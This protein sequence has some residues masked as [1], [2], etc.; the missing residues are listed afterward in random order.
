MTGCFPMVLPSGIFSLHTVIFRSCHNYSQE[1]HIQ[2]PKVTPKST[3]LT[4]SSSLSFRFISVPCLLCVSIWRPQRHPNSL[5]PKLNS[6][7]SVFMDISIR[8]HLPGNSEVIL[9]WSIF[10]TLQTLTSDYFSSLITCLLPA[11]WLSSTLNCYSSSTWSLLSC[12]C[13]WSS[14]CLECKPSPYIL[15]LHLYLYSH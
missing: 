7:R 9:G 5:W 4:Q 15:N 12:H 8:H 6:L 13:S 14:F 1:F 2:P 10:V 11:L 3:S